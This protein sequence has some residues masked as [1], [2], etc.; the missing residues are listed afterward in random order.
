L[1]RLELFEAAVK[2]ALDARFVASQ[3]VEL[4]EENVVVEEIAAGRSAGVELRFHDADAA[5]VPG[6]GDEFVE[7][8]LLEDAL[9]SDVGLV[10]GEQ[11]VEL[12][13]IFGS[14]EKA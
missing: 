7:E 8:G 3:A 4:G 2:G 1:Q 11:F 10:A 12:L 13:A 6:C 9:G 14:D 5:Q